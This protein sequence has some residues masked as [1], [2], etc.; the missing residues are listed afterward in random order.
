MKL[1]IL[2]DSSFNL[3]FNCFW[4]GL[5]ILNMF[6]HIYTLLNGSFLE[7][8]FDETCISELFPDIKLQYDNISLFPTSV[9][10]ILIFE[11]YVTTCPT[12]MISTECLLLLIGLVKWL[13]ILGF[14]NTV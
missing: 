9:E 13:L 11:K 7:I 8:Y 12:S 1:F 10:I 3:L 5:A 2:F 14:K 6:E 4:P